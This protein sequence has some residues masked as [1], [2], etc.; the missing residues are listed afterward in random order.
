VRQGREGYLESTLFN[1]I[2]KAKWCSSDPICIELDAQG[3]DGAN[4][5]ACH[6]CCLL[7][8][9]SCETGNR[10]LDR[11]LLIGTLKDPSVGFFNFKA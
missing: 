4:L 2:E 7:P 6:S 10:L 3:P 11:A 9:T 1:A 8:E 5:A